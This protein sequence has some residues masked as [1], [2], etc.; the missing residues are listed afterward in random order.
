MV[1]G[2]C[3]GYTKC[4]C[5]STLRQFDNDR[6]ISAFACVVFDK[7]RPKPP[8]FGS[9]NGILLRVIIGFATE[10]LDSEQC[11]FEFI[12]LAIEMPFH[13][14]PQKVRQTLA[15][16]ESVARKYRVQFPPNSLIALCIGFHDAQV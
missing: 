9:D 7:F 4:W 2:R 11:L 10:N 1:R 3:V 13:D 6:I 5:V 15:L 14:E 12:I 16:N 8:C